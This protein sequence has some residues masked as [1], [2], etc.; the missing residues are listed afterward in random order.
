MRTRKWQDTAGQDRFSTEII[1]DNFIFLD[2]KGGQ[3]FDDGA[4]ISDHS[5]LPLDDEDMPF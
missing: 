5:D 2:A 4:V 1:V 3:E